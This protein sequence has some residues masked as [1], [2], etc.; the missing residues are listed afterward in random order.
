MGR[1]EDITG[2]EEAMDQLE[3]ELV[4]FT[5][6]LRLLC[7]MDGQDCMNKIPGS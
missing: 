4:R 5:E 6:E 7:G 1:N 3:Q 2:A